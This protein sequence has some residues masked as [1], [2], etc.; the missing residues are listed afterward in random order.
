MLV[1][2]R[3]EIKEARCNLW[4]NRKDFFTFRRSSHSEVKLFSL[5][6]NVTCREA[7]DILYQPGINSVE[8]IEKYHYD[9]DRTF[10]HGS[11]DEYSNNIN[12]SPQPCKGES[13]FDNFMEDQTD[14]F[15]SFCVALSKHEP[16]STKEREGKN[17]DNGYLVFFR[18][19][20][21]LLSILGY[22]IVHY[23]S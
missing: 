6:Q 15:L 13:N 9:E 22:Y 20:A 14:Y 5:Y 12:S 18:I 17:R 7:K 10:E 19:F 1:P 11:D 21:F 23:L 3:K 4:W 16:L 2:E 8:P